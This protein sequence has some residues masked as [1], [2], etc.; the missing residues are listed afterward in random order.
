[1]NLN[2]YQAF[3]FLSIFQI[4]FV[5]PAFAKPV[6]NLSDKP[7]LDHAWRKSEIVPLPAQARSFEKDP[8]S[9]P[10]SL[11]FRSSDNGIWYEPGTNPRVY[12][13]VD[14]LHYTIDATFD[15]GAPPYP[16]NAN[17]EAEATIDAQAKSTPL[18]ELVVDLYDNITID[19]LQLNGELL[20][21]SDNYTRSDN[22]IW[23][24]LSENKTIA[25]SE[26]FE[27]IVKR[28]GEGKN[29]RVDPRNTQ[30]V[31]SLET[32][33]MGKIVV[34]MVVKDKKVYLVFVFS[35]KDYANQGREAIA[36]EYGELVKKLAGKDYMVTGYQVKKDPAMCSI[37]P[38]L[39]P[40]FPKLEDSLKRI[41]LE[42]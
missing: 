1:M 10:F 5:T 32:E 36:K 34:S 25:P 19:S 33:T 2:K 17:L 29:S 8:L 9:D 37:K 20:T 14:V 22:K 27:I 6:I 26:D 7:T 3:I 41:D 31:M 40:M 13:E 15:L 12:Q 39:I 35:E 42:A 11:S 30:V 18:T 28:D 38:Y 23:I 16:N 4:L 21:I 24:T